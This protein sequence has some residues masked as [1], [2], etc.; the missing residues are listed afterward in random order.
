[1]PPSPPPIDIELGQAAQAAQA[2][3]ASQ[4][5]LSSGGRRSARIAGEIYTP[6][7]WGS[8]P[9]AEARRNRRETGGIAS[10]LTSIISPRESTLPVHEPTAGQAPPTL[11]SAPSVRNTQPPP[12][13]QQSRGSISVP[14]A[15]SSPSEHSQQLSGDSSSSSLAIQPQDPVGE[16]VSSSSAAPEHSVPSSLAGNVASSETR[17]QP[18][19]LGD[20]TATQSPNMSQQSQSNT[21]TRVNPLQQVSLRWAQ[22]PEEDRN[23]LPSELGRTV[24]KDVFRFVLEAENANGSFNDCGFCH[25]ELDNDV[26]YV[27]CSHPMHWH[28]IEQGGLDNGCP[29]CP[30]QVANFGSRPATDG[31][32]CHF[33]Q[34]TLTSNDQFRFLGCGNALEPHEVHE[35]CISRGALVNGCP[36]CRNFIPTYGQWRELAMPTPTPSVANPINSPPSGQTNR[37]TPAFGRPF[38][39]SPTSIDNT[40]QPQE[41]PPLRRR[42]SQTIFE[43]RDKLLSELFHI[44]PDL[45][46][47]FTEELRRLQAIQDAANFDLNGWLN[48]F[49]TYHSNGDM[50]SIFMRWQFSDY[51]PHLEIQNPQI[52]DVVVGPPTA[53]FYN[54]I[55]ATID[56]LMNDNMSENPA[57]IEFENANQTRPQDSS[58]AFHPK[59][60]LP[61]ER[62][63]RRANTDGDRQR[64]RLYMGRYI[65]KYHNHP[66]L[67]AL[68]GTFDPTQEDNREQQTDNGAS[69]SPPNATFRRS[70]GPIFG[71]RSG[72]V[73]DNGVEK[74]IGGY[75][76]I[77]NGHQILLRTPAPQPG[78]WDHELIASHLVGGDV[79]VNAYKAACEARGEE[80]FIFVESDFELLRCKTRSQVSIVSRSVFRRYGNPPAGGYLNAPMQHLE[81]KFTDEDGTFWYRKSRLEEKFTVPFIRGLLQRLYEASGI[82]PVLFS[83][84]ETRQRAQRAPRVPR[85]R[86]QRSENANTS[87]EA[88]QA[89][90]PTVPPAQQPT[91]PPAQQPFNPT[92]QQPTVP[93]AQQP[94]NPTAQQ[95]FNPTAQQHFNPTAQQPTVPPAQQPIN[96]LPAALAALEARFGRLEQMMIQFMS[97][98]ASY[99][100]PE[101]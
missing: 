40:P 14:P 27:R 65:R 68:A 98:G 9:E 42:A 21:G 51:Q 73:Y 57:R 13:P 88:S 43:E 44:H 82:S 99:P 79:T 92:A 93:P 39:D 46:P 59:F 3:Q 38:V 66:I 31:E 96:S 84:S 36:L 70:V 19:S 25:E 72:W 2:A 49:R 48:D 101:A 85:A 67:A 60:W 62:M 81:I 86:N 23:K 94:F 24:L 64:V 97:R 77:G 54:A 100:T 10:R 34:C 28:C 6:P 8:D 37:N 83:P 75:R 47:L 33:C 11:A 22:V 55:R 32:E 4:A 7:P 61:H 5:S 26:G 89:P 58:N 45:W 1:M 50:R 56:S 53:S 87:T 90:Q 29:V 95:P 71:P 17:S 76:D 52:R 69:S 30:I 20:R 74:E 18:P 91:V 63:H 12:P 78:F 41:E 80:P 16:F 15:T 35:D